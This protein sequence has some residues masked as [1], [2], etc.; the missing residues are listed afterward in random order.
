MTTRRAPLLSADG[1][2]ILFPVTE[3]DVPKKEAQLSSLEPLSSF[4]GLGEVRSE[5]IVEF[6]D[7]W[8]PLGLCQHGKPY[9]HGETLVGAP[10][11]VEGIENGRILVR[12]RFCPPLPFRVRRL[13]KPGGSWLE[14]DATEAG[15]QD[16]FAEAISAWRHL[17]GAARALRDVVARLRLEQRPSRSD[18]RTLNTALY[19]AGSPAEQI[20]AIAGKEAEPEFTRSEAWFLVAQHLNQWL[21]SAPVRFFCEVEKGS[22]KFDVDFT[23]GLGFGVLPMIAAQ[24]LALLSDPVRGKAVICSGCGLPFIQTREPSRGT[25]RYCL[26]CRRARIPVR[27]AVN[28]SR[29]RKRNREEKKE[30]R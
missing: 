11:V 15:G 4:A 24:L 28:D 16:Y 25:R 14:G 8:G 1:A 19:G 3:Y 10:P 7:I 30:K 29:E 18:I 5:A 23:V 27:D 2:L 22:G 17:A 20:K 9:D 21:S 26:P 6:A 12:P 13:F